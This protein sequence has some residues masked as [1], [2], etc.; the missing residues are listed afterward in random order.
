MEV[1]W[2]NTRESLKNFAK[3]LICRKCGN[4][5]VNP[6]SYTSCGHFFCSHCIDNSKCYQCGIPVR[7]SEIRS[8]HT[9]LSLLRDCDVI[10]NV[11][12]ENNL[13]SAL[14][15]T[16][17]ILQN[18]DALPADIQNTISKECSVVNYLLKNNIKNINKSNPMGETPLHIACIKGQK[19]IV[20]ILL[21]I[22]ADPNTKDNANWS[23]LQE[24]INL[25]HYEICELLLK[26]GAFTNSPG[27]ENRTA[28][29]EAVINNKVEEVKLLLQYNANKEVYDQ[30]GKK[31]ID[32]CYSDEMK[33]TLLNMNVSSINT[34]TEYE[35]NSI[36]DQTFY[37]NNLIVYLSNLSE[38]NK[39]LFERV[40][41]KHKIKFIRTYKPC[42]THII[43]EVNEQNIA[44]LTYD[45]MLALL[46]GKWLLTSEWVSVSLELPNIREAEL[47]LFE[48]S[49]CPT[50]EV[51][52]RARENEEYQNPRLFSR[53]S[54]FLSLQAN[55]V[56]RI[57]DI[58]LTKEKVIKLIKAGDGI[59]LNREPNPEDIKN[60]KQYI[61]FHVAHNPHHPLYKCTHYIIYPAET[62]EPLIIYNMP[63]L[64]SL[65]LL[66][67]IESIEKFTL[68]NPSYI[69]L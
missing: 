52:K 36:F 2:T 21:E 66:W 11:I 14:V 22:G 20:K 38:I 5:P 1:S 65:P 37:N 51:P 28:L 35:L 58:N 27:I 3:T 6:V 46:N 8:D 62:S 26:A 31:P 63:H 18:E 10:A 64:R 32:Y 29:H 54:F 67:L 15:D 60:L 41:A 19:E 48:V 7:I 44:D 24:S 56:Y 68:L 34:E 12:E 43:V 25:G 57:G 13:W 4:K 61:P 17:N 69:G 30:Y 55:V 23:P 49:G 59:I 39:E 42:V 40:V 50:L 45:I 53:C 47:E 16:R 9:I 33:E